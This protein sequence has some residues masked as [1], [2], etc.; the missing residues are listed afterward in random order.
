MLMIIFKDAIKRRCSAFPLFV[1]T[2]LFFCFFA[3]APMYADDDDISM[4][5][6]TTEAYIE[7]GIIFAEQRDFETAIK[8]FSK[9]IKL[10]ENL[11]AAYMLRGRAFYASASYVTSVGENFSSVT[12]TITRGWSNSEERQALYERAIEDFNLAIRLEPD[13]AQSYRE[14]GIV[15]A[16]KGDLEQAIADLDQSILLEPDVVLAHNAR[17]NIHRRMREY[18]LA[19]VD[20]DNAIRLAPD[21]ARAYMNRAG[22][23]RDKGDLDNP[24]KDFTHAISLAPEDAVIYNNRGSLYYAMGNDEMAIKDFNQ[25]IM[26]DP[27]NHVSYLNRAVIFMSKMDYD[28]AIADYKAA[29]RLAPDNSHIKRHLRNVRRQQAQQ[30]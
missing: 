20:Y 21:F 22:T 7:K 16:D 1:F 18:D 2:F 17:G 29:L 30:N 5:L 15:Y 26:L 28:S 14:R 4:P 12:T 6:N 24:I 19:I 23:Y 10:N 11:A 3:K 9:A 8:E 27:N 13:S 25:S